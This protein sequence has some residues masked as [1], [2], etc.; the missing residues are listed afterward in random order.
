MTADFWKCVCG[1]YNAP[2]VGRCPVCRH[3]P[4]S[5]QVAEAVGC[6]SEAALHDEI[7]QFCRAHKWPYVHSRMDQPSTTALGTADFLILAP[8]GK[9]LVCECKTKSGKQTPSQI[10]FQMGC[11]R[12]GHTYHLVRSYEQF[13]AILELEALI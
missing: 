3:D 1:A 8:G 12:N 11:E 7:E 10:G 5:R 6:D 9:T 13:K 2:A 4:K